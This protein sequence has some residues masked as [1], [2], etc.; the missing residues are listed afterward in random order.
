VKKNKKNKPTVALQRRMSSLT[1]KI[2]RLSFDGIKPYAQKPKR[3]D[4]QGNIGAHDLF[5]LFTADVIREKKIFL[6]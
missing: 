2:K 6:R 4:C 5:S 1:V 3:E